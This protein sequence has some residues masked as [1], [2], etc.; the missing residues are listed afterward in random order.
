MIYCFIDLEMEQPSND[1]LEIGASVWDIGKRK[2]INRFQAYIS[3][4]DNAMPSEYITDLCSI[5]HNVYKTSALSPKE[6]IESFWRF[7]EDCKSGGRI[8]A[9]GGDVYWLKQYSTQHN[10]YHSKKIRALDIKNLS[11]P[12]RWLRDKKARGG[13]KSTMDILDLPFE[14]TQHMAYDDAYNTAR[15]FDKIINDYRVLINVE[16]AFDKGKTK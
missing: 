11:E 12:I 15:V 13:L 3:L 7:F 4:P 5:D 14:G 10:A 9:W 2:E 6:G 16:K 8:C 1:L